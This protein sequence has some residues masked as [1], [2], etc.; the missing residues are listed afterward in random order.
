MEYRR[1]SKKSKKGAG[2]LKKRVS[3]AIKPVVVVVEEKVSLEVSYWAWSEYLCLQSFNFI[4]DGHVNCG[5]L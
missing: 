3:V 1:N 5:F 2:I 4:L